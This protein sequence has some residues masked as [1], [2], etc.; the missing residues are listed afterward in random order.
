MQPKPDA[1]RTYLAWL[2]LTAPQVYS[3]ALRKFAGK[4]RSLGGLDRNLGDM[5][6]DDLLNIPAADLPGGEIVV[7]STPDTSGGY[8]LPVLAQDPSAFAPVSDVSSMVSLDPGVS[9]AITAAANAQTNTQNIS[10]IASAVGSVLN[11]ALTTSS[12]ANLVKLNTARVQAGLYPLNAQGQIIRPTVP[13]AVAPGTGQSA[14]ARMEQA[15]AGPGG[16]GSTLPLL[17]I[18]GVAGLALFAFSRR[19]T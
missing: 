8:S 5:G 3:A 13:G 10:A 15:I 6:Q 4:T 11:T 16:G 14:I 1:T 17:L 7:S 9:D 12:Q 19:G 18:A 2:R